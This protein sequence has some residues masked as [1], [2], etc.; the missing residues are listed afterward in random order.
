MLSKF[1]KSF[2]KKEHLLFISAT[3]CFFASGIF[4]FSLFISNKTI[5]IPANGGT[6]TEGIVGQPQYIIPILAKSGTPDQ[7]LSD[8]IYSNLTDLSQSIKNDNQFRTWTVRLKD[9]VK[10]HDGSPI[11]SDDIIFT[12]HTIQNPDSLS[13]LFLD[14]QNIT[15]SRISEREI[16]FKISSSY[17]LF[18]NLLKNLYP[19]P[20]KTFADIAPANIRMS[21]Y[22]LEP[23]GSGP[24]KFSNIEK[25]NDGFVSSISLKENEYYSSIKDLPYIKTINIKFYE[26]EEKIISAYN[27]G[28]ID[29]FGTGNQ[30]TISSIS[31]GS[32][33]KDISTSKYYA[34]FFNSN[35]NSALSSIPLKKALSLAIDKEEIIKDAFIN[36][37]SIANGPIPS[38]LSSFNPEVNDYYSFNPEQ[39]IKTLYENGFDL[40][41]DQSYW[42][43]DG[44]KIVLTIKTP[45]VPTL[46]QTAKIIKKQWEAIHIPTTII[47]IDPQ[48]INDEIVKTRDYEILL[49]GNIVSLEPE[50]FSFWHSS[51]KFYPGLNLSFFDNAIADNQI[52]S[53]RKISIDDQQRQKTLNLI[54]ENIVSSYSTIFLVSPNYFYIHRNNIPGIKIQT[55]SNSSDRFNQISSWYLKTKRQLK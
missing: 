30:S 10:W 1:Y 24:Y 41:N 13:P 16:E 18:P 26:N 33:I 39:S 55:I 50:L 21:I 40:S 37:A 45:D 22:K 15:T 5:K 53:L 3:V 31:L 44:K 4:I 36:H 32:S 11:T 12:I 47:S 52:M 23:I 19:I 14:W 25:R 2:T 43:K 48:K 6:Y 38:S 8:L 7:D 54:Q 49:F 17:S 46:N 20:K 42:I 27:R 9:G 51:E 35:A 34:L 28:A 29:G